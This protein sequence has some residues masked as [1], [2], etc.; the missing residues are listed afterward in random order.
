LE[1]SSPGESSIKDVYVLE[2]PRTREESTDKT[3]TSVALDLRKTDEEGILQRA[4][5][6][7]NM[8]AR[9]G[10][11]RQKGKNQGIN[12]TGTEYTEYSV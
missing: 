11:K 5:G 1:E 8:T 10:L 7:N 4:T 9:A 2:A 3:E 6:N 12:I